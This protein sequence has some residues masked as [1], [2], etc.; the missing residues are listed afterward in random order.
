MSSQGKTREH[1]CV[2][3]NGQYKDE[4]DLCYKMYII[5]CFKLLPYN[6]HNGTNL[7]IAIYTIY[8]ENTL[9]FCHIH[10]LLNGTFSFHFHCHI[11]AVPGGGV[12][13][14][15]FGCQVQHTIKENWTQSNLKFCK[16]EGSKGSKINEK[17]G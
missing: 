9:E 12:L 1:G 3:E 4:R 6:L 15:R 14:K 17:G 8:S 11:Y 16:Y 7:G 5:L 2:R 10:D 13:H